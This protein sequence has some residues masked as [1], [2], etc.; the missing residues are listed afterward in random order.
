MSNASTSTT[1]VALTANP[2][3]PTAPPRANEDTA[4]RWLSIVL[5]PV[6]GASGEK[7]CVAVTLMA[8]PA[9]T[10]VAVVVPEQPASV[11]EQMAATVCT[12]G[13]ML[14]AK[15]PPT[16]LPLVDSAPDRARFSSRMSVVAVTSTPSVDVSVAPCSTRAAVCRF[17]TLI[18]AEAAR[19]VPDLPPAAAKAQ[20]MKSSCLPAGVMASTVM[21]A[22]DT[23][24]PW[25]M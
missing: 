7:A 23:V 6:T 18:P 10:V 14:M 24:A 20:M 13:R 3:P 11:P 19:L 12:A 22:P 5:L 4:G 25:P 9:W 15:A 16:P 1:I 17:R 2:S 8:L 21:P